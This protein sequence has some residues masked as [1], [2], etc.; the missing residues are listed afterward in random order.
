MTNGCMRMI[1]AQR[2]ITNPN[3]ILKKLFETIVYE[4]REKEK[5]KEEEEEEEEEKEIEKDEGNLFAPSGVY[6]YKIPL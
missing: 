5:E 4:E 3:Y 6:C 2:H 1:L